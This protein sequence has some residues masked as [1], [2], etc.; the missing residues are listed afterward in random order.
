MEGEMKRKFN[1]AIL[2][3]IFITVTL[4]CSPLFSRQLGDG[5]FHI[6]SAMEFGSSWKGCWAVPGYPHRFRNGLNIVVWELHRKEMNKGDRNFYFRH[7]RDDIYEIHSRLFPASGHAVGI[8]GNGNS[9]GINIHLWEKDDTYAQRFRLKYQGNGKWKIY[10]M[11]GKVVCLAKG[12]SE[13]GTNVYI[14][15]D[16]NGASC[17]WVLVETGGGH[18][19]FEPLEDSHK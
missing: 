9:N 10:T 12:L 4:T 19:A 8:Y 18:R 14:W 17:E 7:I 15:D 6:Q 11:H 3:G 2:S 16:Y 5:N 1:T 13:E